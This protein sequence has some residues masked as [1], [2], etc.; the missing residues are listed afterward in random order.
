MADL[1]YGRGPYFIKIRR[2]FRSPTLREA[3]VSSVENGWG[4]K[5]SGSTHVF[6]TNGKT[7]VQL[8]A[9]EP[10]GTRSVKNQVAILKRKG[11]FATE[12]EG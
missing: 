9:T 7:S 8:S 11:A 4:Y 12:R 1:F 10:D 6:L 2:A 5:M 3:F